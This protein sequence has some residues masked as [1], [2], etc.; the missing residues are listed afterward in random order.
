[1]FV[2]HTWTHVCTG[3]LTLMRTLTH[4]RVHI[5]T[6]TH[7]DGDLEIWNAPPQTVRPT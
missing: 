7:L 4:A 1:M 6:H 2:D 3:A 5:D